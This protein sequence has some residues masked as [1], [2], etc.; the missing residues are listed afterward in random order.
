MQGQNIIE[1]AVVNV[2]IAIGQD[3]DEVFEHMV[4]EQVILVVGMAHENT[5]GDSLVKS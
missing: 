4:P 3:V 5:I 1:G 2:A